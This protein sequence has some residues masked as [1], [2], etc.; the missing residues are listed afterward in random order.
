MVPVPVPVVVRVPPPGPAPVQAELPKQ[1]LWSCVGAV[2][3]QALVWQQAQE[4]G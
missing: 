2:W 4:G 1:L 3:R